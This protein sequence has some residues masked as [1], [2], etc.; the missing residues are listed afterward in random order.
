M[1]EVEDV[2]NS[3]LLIAA[4]VDNERSRSH[5]ANPLR[6]IMVRTSGRQRPKTKGSFDQTFAYTD[7]SYGIIFGNERYNTLEIIKGRLRDQDL[8]IHETTEPFKS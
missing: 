4:I 8:E 1:P 3:H 2:H 5:L 7:C 6:R